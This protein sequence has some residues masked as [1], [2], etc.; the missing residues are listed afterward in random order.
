MFSLLG[1]VDVMVGI[2]RLVSLDPAEQLWRT[3][4]IGTG[5]SVASISATPWV[6]PLP[7]GG[8]TGLKLVF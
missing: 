2:I 3:W 5:Q 6:T 7:G 1:F 8:A 4:R